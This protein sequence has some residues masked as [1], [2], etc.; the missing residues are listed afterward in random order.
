MQAGLNTYYVQADVHHLFSCHAV[1]HAAFLLVN[2]FQ[3][4][5]GRAD[6]SP[7]PP[8]SHFMRRYR[9]PCASSN[10][11]QCIFKKVMTPPEYAITRRHVCAQADAQPPTSGSGRNRSARLAFS[12]KKARLWIL[13]LCQGSEELCRLRDFSQLISLSSRLG[14]RERASEEASCR[15]KR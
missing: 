6:L 11:S 10:N 7:A 8:I 13:V 5:E 12:A 15:K 1:R 2:G 9:C 3:F 4:V 14:F